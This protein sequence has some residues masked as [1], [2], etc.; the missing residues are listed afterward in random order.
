M[1]ALW[2]TCEHC[3]ERR[4]TSGRYTSPANRKLDAEQWRAEHESRAC[5][6]GCLLDHDAYP[7]K[8]P[9]GGRIARQYGGA[10]GD[11][12]EPHPRFCANRAHYERVSE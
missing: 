12:F 10:P 8:H 9:N 11:I 7:W 5:V 3:G 2:I 1:S 6:D 4:D